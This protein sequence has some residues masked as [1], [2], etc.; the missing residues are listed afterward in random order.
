MAGKRLYITI[1]KRDWELMRLWGATNTE[2][3]GMLARRWVLE[4]LY[5]I[6]R[7]DSA[8][9]DADAKLAMRERE[10]VLRGR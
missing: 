5:R 8:L 6:L 4:T 10:E 3:P 9:Q 1:P 7:E 2:C